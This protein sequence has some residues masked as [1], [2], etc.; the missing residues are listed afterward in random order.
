MSDGN[1]P[2]NDDQSLS[3]AL[4]SDLDGLEEEQ[5]VTE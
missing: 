3:E 2:L 1:A 5:G 4:E